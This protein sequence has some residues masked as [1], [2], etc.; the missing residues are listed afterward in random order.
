MKNIII[1][2]LAA[3]PFITSCKKNTAT[4]D[5]TMQVREVA[6]NS[7]SDQEK[8]TVTTDW[9]Q[10]PVAAS[11][12]KQKNAY[13]VTFNTSMDALLGPITIYVDASSIVVLGRNLRE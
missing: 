11:T 6:W 4:A 2:F 12:F 7:L 13:A 1:L 9:K 8:K 5:L 3:I 10:A